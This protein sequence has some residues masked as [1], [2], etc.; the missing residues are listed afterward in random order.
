MI[1]TRIRADTSVL[2]SSFRHSGYTAMFLFHRFIVSLR[3]NLQFMQICDFCWNPIRLSCCLPY[4]PHEA[5][6]P[7]ASIRLSRA[8]DLLKVKKRRNFNFDGDRSNRGPNLRSTVKVAVKWERKCRKWFFTRNVVRN[9][10]VYITP[11]HK[12]FLADSTHSYMYIVEYISPAF[13][14]I[15]LSVCLSVCLV[16]HSVCHVPH[17]PFAQSLNIGTSRVF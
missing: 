6:P 8:Y 17:I 1:S 12:M 15:C 9:R 4:R 7:C 16:C 10:S 2:T 14:D 13:C 5:L 3:C 11:K